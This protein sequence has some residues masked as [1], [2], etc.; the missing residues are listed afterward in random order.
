MKITVIGTGYVGL[1]SGACHSDIGIEV[2]CVDI[3][4][5]KID[6]L[7]NGFL[8]I[9]EPGLEEIINLTGIALKVVY[10][11][12]PVNDP[13]QRQPDISKAKS[14]LD[15]EP[16]VMRAEGLE[17]TYAWFQQLPE[18]RLNRKEHRTFYNYISK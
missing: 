8:P 14:M 18:D 12:L 15:W 13:M 10:Q 3:D 11:P 16:K 7:K 1:V 2:T 5:K 6:C 9:Y 17:K 4:Q